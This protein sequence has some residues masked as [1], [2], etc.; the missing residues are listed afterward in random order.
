MPADAARLRRHSSGLGRFT[1]AQTET[2]SV[3][4]DVKIAVGS[5]HSA[6]LGDLKPGDQ[7]SI[8][9]AQ[10]H[11]ARVAHHIADGVTHNASKPGKSSAPKTQT[12]TGTS[13][14]THAHGIV[15][16]VDL[17]AGTMTIAHKRR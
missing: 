7:V 3:A 1:A 4:S 14:L 10:E 8:G 16:S 9:Y 11:G 6:S 5:N 12:H 13:A 17:Q 15:Q 2:F